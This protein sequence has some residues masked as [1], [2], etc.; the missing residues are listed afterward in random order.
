M[1]EKKKKLKKSNK[2][3]SKTVAVTFK[4]GKGKRLREYISYHV[5]CRNPNGVEQTIAHVRAD[6]MESN[7]DMFGFGR[8]DRVRVIDLLQ[9]ALVVAEEWEWAW[10]FETDIREEDPCP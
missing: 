7:I 1:R 4:C 8:V 9:G 6:E 2:N 10:D 3:K 5:S